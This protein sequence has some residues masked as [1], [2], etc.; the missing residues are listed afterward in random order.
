MFGCRLKV[1]DPGISTTVRSLQSDTKYVFPNNRYSINYYPQC[2][3]DPQ[4][5][6]LP[7]FLSIC[8][9]LGVV[10]RFRAVFTESMTLWSYGQQ[11]LKF[12][13]LL[14][15][16]KLGTHVVVVFWVVNIYIYIYIYIYH[17]WFSH[18]LL[19]L[20]LSSLSLLLYNQLHCNLPHAAPSGAAR[21][22]REG[23]ERLY[24]STSSHIIHTA[25]RI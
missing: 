4:R 18:N 10:V 22:S 6:T 15:L 5:K 9:P 23:P 13:L 8:F 14:G 1:L 20:S 7:R 2:C 11:L 16:K 12:V 17:R 21:N 19:L 24:H 25:Y 3:H